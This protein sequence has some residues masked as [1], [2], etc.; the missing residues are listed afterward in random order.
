MAQEPKRL[1]ADD[2]DDRQ[3]RAVRRYRDAEAANGLVILQ[4]DSTTLWMSKRGNRF[5]SVERMTRN[6]RGTIGIEYRCTC[7]DFQKNG[8]IDCEH[9]FAER[10]RR[11]EVVIEGKV[12]PRRMTWATRPRRPPRK[13]LS[14]DGQPIRSIQRAARVEIDQ[15]VPELLRD[16]VMLTTRLARGGSRTMA[17]ARAINRAAALALKLAYGK[18]YD[19]IKPVLE[20]LIGKGV[21]QLRKVPHQN[22]MSQWMN[23]PALTPILEQMLAATAKP[24]RAVEC[25]AIVDSSKM[26]Q[27]RTAHPRWI[28]YGDDQRDEASWMKLHAL[29]GVESLICLAAIFSGTNSGNGT[30]LVHDVNFLLALVEKAL[31]TF[32][33]RYVLGDKAYLS[34]KNVGMLHEWGI[35]AVIP[36]KKRTDGKNMKQFYE[37]FQGLVKWYDE[38]Q[39]DFHE[40][41]RLRPKVESYFSLLKGVT[42]G[43]CW[44]RGR[45]RKDAAGQCIDNSIEPCTAWKNETLC[46]LIYVNLRV[47]VQYEI[48]TGYRM[49]YLADT[50]FPAIP[51]DQRLIA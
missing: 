11:R 39:A 23:D 36:L 48:S 38:R 6:R 35:R 47:T 16:L 24:F 46:K 14:A 33:L 49:N 40:V 50:F 26:S 20:E 27:M 37:A 42:A 1:L 19:A 43:F 17:D 9:I 10:L 21:L 34:E 8:R 22:T 44:S 3:I 12:E 41:Y 32:S 45:P 7:A 4:D 18:S 5:W 31:G 30:Y 28:E 25:A 51:P 13:R 2:L 29:V 15:R